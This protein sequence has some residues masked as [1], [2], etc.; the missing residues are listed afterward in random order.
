MTE[1]VVF[2]AVADT[3]N[4]G[5]HFFHSPKGGKMKKKNH[6]DPGPTY[7]RTYTTN[8]TFYLACTFVCVLFIFIVVRSIFFFILIFIYYIFFYLFNFFFFWV[9]RFMLF[10]SA[11]LW[12]GFSCIN[13]TLTSVCTVNRVH[14]L[15]SL[16]Y[17]HK[18][19]FRLRYTNFMV[20]HFAF[21]ST[22]TEKKK[23]RKSREKYKQQ[24]K[25][26]IK[27]RENLMYA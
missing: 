19:C 15:L 5:M 11:F 8:M 4:D 27:Y 3:S 21:T 20:V 18:N 26:I 6:H 10:S 22:T 13:H 24:H 23:Y 7:R 14:S 2:M 25:I 12:L 16:C 9:G 1:H 17:Q